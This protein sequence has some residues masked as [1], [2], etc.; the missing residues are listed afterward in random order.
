MNDF[1]PSHHLP[2]LLSLSRP[3]DDRCF[4][5]IEDYCEVRLI[6]AV[7][8]CLEYMGSNLGEVNGIGRKGIR[9]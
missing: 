7:A 9:P 8:K 3:P 2:Q 4:V 1:S 6:A 5:I